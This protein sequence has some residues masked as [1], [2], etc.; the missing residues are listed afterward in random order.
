VL[1]IG[2]NKP[3]LTKEQADRLEAVFAV[4][5]KPSTQ[6]KKEL[7]NEMGVEVA[8]V[9][10]RRPDPTSECTLT[11]CKPKKTNPF[12]PCPLSAAYGG[13]SRTDPGR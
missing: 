9:N 6:K 10:V 12:I 8:K 1:H 5:Y 11:R 2:E 4:E 13:P 3:R 7:A